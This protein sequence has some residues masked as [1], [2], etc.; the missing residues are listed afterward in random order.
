MVPRRLRRLPE[1]RDAGGPR[2]FVACS[3][4]ARLLG[5][6]LLKEMPADCAL[7]LPGCSSIHTFGMRFPIDVIFL[8]RQ[9]RVLRV[10]R[11]VG[12]GRVLLCRGAA[13]VLEWRSLH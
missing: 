7:L 8:D 12:P 11:C 3:F 1:R 5:L 4:R 10:D 9:G 13:E 2:V 6:A